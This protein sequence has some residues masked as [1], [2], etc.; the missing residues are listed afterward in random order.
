MDK[1]YKAYNR[2]KYD[3]GIQFIDPHKQ[4]NVRAGSFALLPEDEISFMHSVSTV[5]SGKNLSFDEPEV[6]V[7]ILGFDPEEKL[8]LSEEEIKTIL[9]SGL[10][11]MKV[12]LEV[13]TEPNFK[14]LIFEEAK[15]MYSDLTGAK[16]EYIAEYCGKEP[17]DMKP[18]KEEVEDVKSKSGK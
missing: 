18:V 14:F 8:S 17:E 5:F 11:K 12:S 9:K 3:V 7:D 10:P 16:I 13:I 2:N 6:N 4:Q 1:K 15:K